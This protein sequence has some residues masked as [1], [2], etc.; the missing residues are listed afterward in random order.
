[1]WMVTI[2]EA[3]EDW[4]DWPVSGVEERPEG[5]RV[6]FSNRTVATAF[7]RAF[8]GKLAAADWTPDLRY[9]AEWKAFAVGETWWLAPAGDEGATPPGR[10][11]LTMQEGLVFGSGDHPTTQ[12]CLELLERMP[13][14]GRRVFDLGVG[15]GILSLAAQALGAVGVAG[16][17]TDWEAA[18][19]A[20]ADGLA[21]W[22]GPS[23]AARD[24]CAEVLLVNIPGYVHLQ[25]AEEYLRL[26]APGGQLLLSG[27]YDWQAARI[28]AAL[29]GLAKRHQIVRGDAWI[30]AIFS[31][32]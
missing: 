21:V 9:Q 10:R 7:S 23:A 19:M 26:L 3:L 4:G 31:H 24:G 6:Y 20:H 29:R 18:Q 2:G 12:G 17:D 5:A 15:T 8:G 16:C 14:A 11:R 32:A 28:E 25:L 13:V 30:S 1:M 22:C 27:Y